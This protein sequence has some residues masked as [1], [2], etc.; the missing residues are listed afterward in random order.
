MQARTVVV[1]HKS[2]ANQFRAQGMPAGTEAWSVGDATMGK[3]VDRLIVAWGWN[4]YDSRLM[5]DEGVDWFMTQVKTR[6]KPG[7]KVE[8]AV[9]L[10][11]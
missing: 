11:E 1:C 10:P 6:C 5:Q 7:V 2:D 3:H 4:D 8:L 9:L